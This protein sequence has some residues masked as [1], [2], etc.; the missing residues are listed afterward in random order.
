MTLAT[1][2]HC[3]VE[4]DSRL[5]KPVGPPDWPDGSATCHICRGAYG[6]IDDLHEQ[7]RID[8]ARWR[9]LLPYM[10]TMID[11][12]WQCP[13]VWVE[14]RSFTKPEKDFTPTEFVDVLVKITEEKKRP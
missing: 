7:D 5:V 4:C 3:G 12:T 1:C 14:T 9:A 13:L 8:A 11:E 6:E 2:S 10:R